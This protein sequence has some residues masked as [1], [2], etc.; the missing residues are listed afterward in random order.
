M[1]SSQIKNTRYKSNTGTTRW[2]TVEEI[3]RSAVKVNLSDENYPAGG[4]PVM[5][6]GKTA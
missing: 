6:D 1:S 3:Q 5:S 2:A 4:I